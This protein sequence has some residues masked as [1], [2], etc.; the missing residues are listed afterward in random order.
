MSSRSVGGGAYVYK[1]FIHNL[2]FSRLLYSGGR[3]HIETMWYR[4]AYY[5][6]NH[7]SKYVT[8]LPDGSNPNYC[9]EVRFRRIWQNRNRF[10]FE[11]GAFPPN[12]IFLS[13]IAR[14]ISHCRCAIL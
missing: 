6:A 11:F 5:Q 1:F 9:R 7:G 13:Y 2:I 10:R 4:V 3:P 8:Y 14:F 12:F